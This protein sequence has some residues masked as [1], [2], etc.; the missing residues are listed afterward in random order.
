MNGGVLIMTSLE[1][2]QRA[3]DLICEVK[4]EV[5]DDELLQEFIDNSISSIE[6][7]KKWFRK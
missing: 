6:L 2:I 5:T 7:V 1:K 4:N 3:L